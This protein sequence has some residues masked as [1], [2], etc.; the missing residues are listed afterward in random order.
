MALLTQKQL[1]F[2]NEYL[3]DG[4]GTQAAI[5]AGYSPKTARSIAAE[6]LK[7]PRIAGTI[8]RYKLQ[9][10]EYADED[11]GRIVQM[12]ARLAFADI[13]EIF[14]PNGS[15]KHPKVWPRQI[16]DRINFAKS[17]AKLKRAAKG[18]RRAKTSDMDD[19]RIKILGA[20]ENYLRR[21][22]LLF[23]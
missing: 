19:E 13:P 1:S 10:L 7:K 5:R 23:S 21:R 17:N 22:G 14:Y 8:E 15:L 20:M 3:V 18:R 11:R 9:A 2:I 16:L 6:N 12:L 4:N